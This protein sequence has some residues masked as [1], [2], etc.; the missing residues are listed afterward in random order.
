MGTVTK[1]ARRT[2]L[3]GTL[4]VSGGLA[5]GYWHFKDPI[6]NPILANLK[7]GE[8]ALTHYV[9]INKEG[10]SIITP[11][12]EMGQGVQSTLAALVAEELDVDWNTIKMEHGPESKAYA[13][14]GL[15]TEVA[16]VSVTDESNLANN[17]RWAF[18]NIMGK[19]FTSI[20][21]TGG[22]SAMIDGFEKMRLAGA[23]AR[24]VLI[25]A[26]AKQLNVDS[27]Q[28]ATQDGFVIGNNGIRLSYEELAER[29][30]EIQPPSKPKL[31]PKSE[32]RYL[33]KSL[34][35]LDMVEKSTGIA[36]YAI[37]IR[38]PGMVYAT[39]KMNPYRGAKCIRYNEQKALELPG[40]KEVIDLENGVA[41][42][43]T[44]TW[45]AMQGASA[46]DCEWEKVNY[47][48][49]NDEFYS[50]ALK[51]FN[52][53]PDSVHNISG[54]P[55][56]IQEGNKI[57]LEYK[58][59]YQSHATM[60]PLGATALLK[61]G[62]F[63]I[64]VGTQSP[65]MVRQKSAEVI[66]IP[67]EDCHVHTLYM[68]GGFGRR[69]EIDF[70]NQVAKIAKANEGTPVKLTWTREEDIG[71]DFYRPLSISRVKLV[72][73]EGK[74]IGLDIKVAAS[75]VIDS[76]FSD[77]WG[78]NLP[79]PDATLVQPIPDQPYGLDHYRV[80]AFKSPINLPVGSWRSVGCSQNG[81]FHECAMDELALLAGED[82]LEM[83]LRLLTHEPSRQVVK[84]VKEMS[85]WGRTLPADHGLGIAFVLSFGVPTAQIFEVKQ[86]EFGIKIENI[87]AAVDV[88][89]A[90]DPMNIEA[91]V[92]GGII[93]G[94][95]SAIM[96]QITVENGRVVQSN[97]HDF[98]ILK[99][100]QTP[101][102]EVK[103]LENQRNIK[104]IG[105]P[106]TPP[107]AP[108]LANA[109][110]AT[111]GKRIRELPMNKFIDF[112]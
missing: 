29:A 2:F 31:K 24:T 112:A 75:S 40:V 105:E 102:M 46:L 55:D 51:A 50:E 4:G 111:T 88:G 19:L 11:R 87:W 39:V 58:V 94:L 70:T 9:K 28:L 35:R 85:G 23:A 100:Y 32:W 96:G 92:T 95:S 61:D 80:Q 69:S 60:E 101:N 59:P 68:G 27:R 22:S 26:A 81:F 89:V 43:A 84:A 57:E 34:P 49:N 15:W 99:L 5:V 7:D 109:I 52:D 73:K 33:G 104:G 93:Y 38:L 36:T 83:R 25:K 86:T 63:D 1:I 103:I 42:V 90:L 14:T 67:K 110:F 17:L 74:G 16:P 54:D 79:G 72:A 18:G 82:P 107:A 37:D 12:A 30:T 77:R 13:N 41:V 6:E 97:F 45:Y 3:L 106:G 56:S 78:I 20:Q 66:G 91:Q 44:N 8:F 71:Q 76:K 21:T 53:E 62:R 98:E 10:V 47:K 65:S 64:W 108:A 48:G